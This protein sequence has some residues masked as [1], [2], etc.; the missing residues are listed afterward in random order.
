MY[1]KSFKQVFQEMSDHMREDGALASDKRPGAI[2]GALMTAV[3][4]AISMGWLGLSE[5]YAMFFVNLATGIH[6]RRRVRDLGMEPNPG[7]FAAGRVMLIPANSGVI[8]S[9][10]TRGTLLAGPG[11]LLYEVQANTPVGSPFTTALVTCTTVGTAGNLSAGTVLS[12]FNIT[13]VNVTFK[14][15]SALDAQSLATGDLQ[16]GLD[17]ETDEEIKQRFPAYL[18]GL[19]RC[20]LSAVRQALQETPGVFNLVLQNHTPVPGWITV[21]VTTADDTISTT[22]RAAVAAT[23]EAFSAAGVGYVLKIVQKRQ[24][25]VGVHVTAIDSNIAPSVWRARVM[26][27]IRTVTQDLEAGRSIYVEDIINAGY[28]DGLSYFRVLFPGDSIAATGEILVI[29]NVDVAVDYA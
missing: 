3:A 26:A 25:N 24:I 4:A 2:L 16:G 28:I 9:V 8:G 17:P 27:A 20:T 7:D 29:G 13:G 18:V 10:V 15:G 12:P 1:F 21:S 14:V 6:L 11:N 22:L 19:S 23:M 5:I